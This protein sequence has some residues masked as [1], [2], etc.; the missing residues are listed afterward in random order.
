MI[1]KLIPRLFSVAVLVVAG[2]CAVSQVVP[3]AKSGRSALPL[4]WASTSINGGTLVKGL[5][6][7]A[8]QSAFTTI[9]EASTFPAKPK[10]SNEQL[11]PD[12]RSGSRFR[13]QRIYR[14]HPLKSKSSPRY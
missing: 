4:V 11:D 1:T 14:P 6:Q 13:L 2:S 12:V 9:S 3:A 10:H 5:H 8:F 7:T